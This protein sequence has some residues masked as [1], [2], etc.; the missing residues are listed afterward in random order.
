M[1]PKPYAA[2]LDYN[3]PDKY[4][5][6]IVWLIAKISL[7]CC[8]WLAFVELS[9]VSVLLSSTKLYILTEPRYIPT[10]L[11]LLLSVIPNKA[12]IRSINLVFPSIV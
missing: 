2:R 8:S 6:L 7:T 5:W 3:C 9:S 11:I 4:N 12:A 10:T 1:G